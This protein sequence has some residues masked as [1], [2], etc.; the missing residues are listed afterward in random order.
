[1]IDIYNT[2]RKR[3]ENHFLALAL[4]PVDLLDCLVKVFLLLT[5]LL[6]GLRD[7]ERSALLVI[8]ALVV[9]ATS[10]WLNVLRAGPFEPLLVKLEPVNKLTSYNV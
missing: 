2:K 7:E 10:P 5:L 3:T 1:M 6:S 9:R 4:L 8:G